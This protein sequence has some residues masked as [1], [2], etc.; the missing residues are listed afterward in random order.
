MLEVNALLEAG[1]SC[2]DY[3]GSVSLLC[4]VSLTASRFVKSAL[5]LPNDLNFTA[6]IVLLYVTR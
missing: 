4:Q 2:R 5:L 3:D 6:S 1:M